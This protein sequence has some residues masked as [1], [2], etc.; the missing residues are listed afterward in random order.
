MRCG[1]LET[2]H[3][4]F[5][6]WKIQRLLFPPHDPSQRH[7]GKSINTPVMWIKSDVLALL[8][9]LVTIVFAIVQAAWCLTVRP[10]ARVLLAQDIVLTA[11][12][13]PCDAL[14]TLQHVVMGMGSKA[15]ESHSHSRSHKHRHSLTHCRASESLP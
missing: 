7:S 13:S 3:Q 1:V 8:Q 12:K 2:K 5:W 14:R 15:R 4:F 6:P 10:G 9:L 11:L